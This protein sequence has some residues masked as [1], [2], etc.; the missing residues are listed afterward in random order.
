MICILEWQLRTLPGWIQVEAY[1]W[2]GCK[3][4][5]YVWV[6]PRCGGCRVGPWEALPRQTDYGAEEPAAAMA[7]AT[8]SD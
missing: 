8:G 6:C 3:P 4:E 2:I 1:K 5:K 7:C